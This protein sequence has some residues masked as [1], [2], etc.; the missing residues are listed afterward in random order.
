VHLGGNNPPVQ[1]AEKAY[2]YL[3]NNIPFASCLISTPISPYE[4]RW[5]KQLS[6]VVIKGICQGTII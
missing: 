5:E 2:A 1:K 4:E 3:I 6:S